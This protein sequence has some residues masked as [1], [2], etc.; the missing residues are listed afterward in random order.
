MYPQDSNNPQFTAPNRIQFLHQTELA[1]RWHISPKTLERWR[2]L[3]EGPPFHKIRGR[4][5]YKLADIEAYETDN[6]RHRT[7][8]SSAALQDVDR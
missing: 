8:E 4:V 7:G 5:L 3:G 2:W 1:S 6:V